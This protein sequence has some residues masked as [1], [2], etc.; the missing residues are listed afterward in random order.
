MDIIWDIECGNGRE[1]EENICCADCFGGLA[2]SRGETVQFPSGCGGVCCEKCDLTLNE[3]FTGS[4]ERVPE[5]QK[6][7]AILEFLGE[8]FGAVDFS[9]NVFYLD[10][11]VLLLAFTEKKS[12]RL[13]CL[14][15]FYVVVLAQLQHAWFLL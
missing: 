4:H 5:G 11:E 9:G 1:G 12:L 7:G 6:V 3:G 8:N 10:C 2:V 15:P 13:R 14:R